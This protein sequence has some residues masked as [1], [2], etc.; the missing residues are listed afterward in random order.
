MPPNNIDYGELVV[1]SI[2]S[3]KNKASF[4]F[5]DPQIQSFIMNDLDPDETFVELKQKNK[6]LGIMGVRL[7]N[8]ETTIVNPVH[9]KIDK[10]VGKVHFIKRPNTGISYCKDCSVEIKYTDKTVNIGW[11]GNFIIED[12]GII[13]DQIELL[14]ENNEQKF[15][16]PLVIHNNIKKLGL[17]LEVPDKRTIELWN[18]VQPTL[19]INGIVYGNY[20]Y[21]K[22]YKA[23]L[24]GLDNKI[25]IEA[26]YFDD[27]SGN[28]SKSKYSASI[29]KFLFPDISS[30]AYVLYL[31]AGTQ[32][33]HTR[34]INVAAGTTTIIY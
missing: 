15:L 7:R 23:F 11:N 9:K 31:V 14:I 21:H 17:D 3:L 12:I 26:L 25:S 1:S 27:V 29:S 18:R 20:T 30:G 6:S 28:L 24:R 19:P 2:R 22:S 34:T 32:I 8:N 5:D 13:D 10:L 33:I 16:V 4:S